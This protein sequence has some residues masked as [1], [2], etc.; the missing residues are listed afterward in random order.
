MIR[1]HQHEGSDARMLA[2]Y[3]WPWT[4]AGNNDAQVNDVCIDEHNFSMPWNSR[5]KSSLWAIRPE[6]KEQVGCIHTS[7]GLEFDYVGV[8]FGNDITFDPLTGRVEGVYEEYYDRTGKSGLRDK[9]E[10][11][12]LY[13]KSIYKILCSRGM[14]GCYVF[15]RDEKLKRYMKQRLFAAENRQY[16]MRH[17]H[18]TY[19]QVADRNDY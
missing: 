14:K 19:T 7:Q 8:L 18:D 13:I 16:D 6:G 5:T 2:G 4:S 11:L 9:P 1:R 10:E 3:A 17:L 15:V 12:T